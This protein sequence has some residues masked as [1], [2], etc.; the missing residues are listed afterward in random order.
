MK[1]VFLGKP[2]SGKGTQAE[3]LTQKLHIPHIS[4]GELL[5]KEI[6]KKTPLGRKI[7]PLLQK[8][9]LISDTLIFSVLQ[10]QLPKD[11]FLLDGFPRNV[12][13]AQMLDKITKINLVV[14]VFC[15]DQTILKRA[16]AR[17][18]CEHCGKVYGL[19]PQPKK[20]GVC[21]V[22]QGKL[23]RRDDDII[24]TVRK[25]LQVYRQEGQKLAHYYKQRK[26][27]FSV[28]GEDPILQVQKEIL[29]KIESIK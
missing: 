1:L 2:L 15:S 24:P 8:G 3:L 6:R 13:Q 29:R 22:C 7:A 5:R 10:K 26:I 23:L 25:R 12:R 28:H 20:M 21:T 14:D 16:A 27:Y 19:H 11:H 18:T 17:Q 4:T 9:K